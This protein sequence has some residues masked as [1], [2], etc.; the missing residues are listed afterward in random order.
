[1]FVS[2]P[3]KLLRQKLTTSLRVSQILIF[4][5][6]CPKLYFLFVFSI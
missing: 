2:A 1:M 5:C 6:I 4:N 3:A